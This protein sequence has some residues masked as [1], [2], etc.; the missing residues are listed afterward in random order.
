M[1]EENESVIDSICNASH[2]EPQQNE[3]DLDVQM[4]PQIKPRSSTHISK[5]PNKYKDFKMI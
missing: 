1:D 5:L 4:G 3:T 2:D